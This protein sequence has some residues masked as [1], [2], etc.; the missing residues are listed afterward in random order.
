MENFTKFLGGK[1]SGALRLMLVVVGMVASFNLFSQTTYY[2]IGGATS[3]DLTVA[4]MW[5]LSL[6]G[7]SAGAITPSASNIF[8]VDGSDISSTTGTQTGAITFNPTANIAF[9]QFKLINNASLTLTTRTY[10]VGGT[11]SGDD[12]IV[13]SGSTLTLGT[14][15]DLT[16]ASSSP[17]STAD[18]SGSFTINASRTWTVT[19]SACSVKGGSII[20]TGLITG[21]STSTLIFEGASTYT[22]NQNGGTIPTADWNGA[23]G[24]GTSTCTVTGMTSTA[25]SGASQ[26]FYNL[27][28]NS[29][30]QSTTIA[31]TSMTISNNLTITATG[32]TASNYLHI[33][34]GN[35][36]T[37][38][39]NYSQ[40]GGIF[41]VRQTGANDATLSVSG[42]VSI[43]GG[44]FYGNASN[45]SGGSA[46][47]TC[48][49][50]FSFSAGTIDLNTQSS[51]T[52]VIDCKGDF[53]HT[54]GTIT[55]SGAGTGNIT[56]TKTSNTQTL[57]ST[58]Q[59]GDIN[60]TVSGSNA[61]C[62]VSS[63][64]TFVLGTTATFTVSNGTS[65]IDLKID[66]TFTFSGAAFTMN[67]TGSVS[68]TGTYTH[69][70][71]NWSST[72]A[73]PVFTWVSG[74]TCKVTGVTSSNTLNGINQTFSNF[75]WNC[76]TQSVDIDL[77]LAG[78]LTSF[79]C[80]DKFT[81]MSTGSGGNILKCGVQAS[82]TFTFN[83]GSMEIQGG[84][85]KLGDN[86]QLVDFN[87]TG[88][89]TMNG[90]TIYLNGYTST[91]TVDI[92]GNLD[93]NSGT[94]DI[95]SNTGTVTLTVTGNVS[96]DGG[97]YTMSSGS[98]NTTSS[99]SVDGNFTTSGSPTA[100]LGGSYAGHRITYNIKGDIDFATGGM[101][102]SNNAAST[103]AAIV[104]IN[105][106]GSGSKT[107]KLPTGL[108]N[109][110]GAYWKWIVDATRTVTLQSNVELGGSTANAC[111]FVNNG[112]LIM[113]T[114]I[115]TN[116]AS[117]ATPTFSNNASAT[118][119][120]AHAQGISTTASTG[121][122][123]V[124]GTKTFYSTASYEFN[125]NA[126]QVT[127]DFIVTTTPVTYTV[128]NLTLNNTAGVTLS[129]NITISNS[130]T[131][132]LTAGDHDL[133]TYTLTLGTTA[134]STLTY[135][136]G[137]LYS[138]SNAGYFKRYIPAG[139]VTS[140]SSNYYGLFPM[141]TSLFELNSTANTTVG[142]Y[143]TIQPFVNATP[144]TVDVNYSDGT[145]TIDYILN[146]NRIAL[147]TTSISGGT[148]TVKYSF[149]SFNSTGNA[150]DICLATY[151]ASTIGSQGTLVA[152][153][154][155]KANPVVARSSVSLANLAQTWVLGTYNNTNSPITS[156]CGTISGTRTVGTGGY[157][158]TLR[159]A[160]TDLNT[161]GIKGPTVFELL[162]TYTSTAE[163]LASS[164]LTITYGG[165]C[166]NSTNNVT[167]RPESA[168]NSVLS[169]SAANTSA[170][171]T[172]DGA[173]YIT[174]DGRPG[175]TGTNEYISITNTSIA[176]G[177]SAILFQN[178]ATNNNLQ[179]LNL[180]SSFPSATIGVVTFSGT[181]TT[182]GN[183]SNTIDNCIIDGNAGTNSSP[184]S[185]SSVARN[186][187][188]SGGNATYPNSTN[189]ISNS[190]FKNVFFTNST[191][192]SKM[193]A[194]D[195][196]NSSWTINGNSF[197]QTSPRQATVSALSSPAQYTS[198]YCI[199]ILG[200]DGYTISS[201]YIGGSS[202]N[203]S[204]TWTH[205]QGSDL[206]FY[207]I[208]FAATAGGQNSTIKSNT[209]SNFSAQIHSYK[210][211]WN[212]IVV[213]SGNVTLGGNTSADGNTI[214][215]SSGTGAIELYKPNGADG[216]TFTGIDITSI[217]TVTIKNNIIG[218]IKITGSS[219]Y[220]DLRGITTK[221][222][223]TYTISNNTIGTSTPNSIST[224]SASSS[225]TMYGIYNTGTGF[226]T[227]S[228]N[229]IG[230]FYQV[231]GSFIG[232][233]DYANA[234]SQHTISSNTI[235][236]TSTSSPV[237]VAASADCYG[238]NVDG[239]GTYTV[240]SNTIQNLYHTASATINLIGI[241]L[242]STGTFTVSNNTIDKLYNNTVGNY[243][244]YVTGISITA[245]I[246]ITSVIEKNSL[247]NFK[248]LNTNAPLISGISAFNT[249]LTL[250]AYNNFFECDNEGILN[251]NLLKI[252]GIWHQHS[253]SA[254][255]LNAYHNTIKISGKTS[256]NSTGSS[257]YGINHSGATGSTYNVQNNLIINTRIDGGSTSVQHVL[258]NLNNTTQN[259]N[260][261]FNKDQTFSSGSGANSIYNQNGSNSEPSINSDGSL[262][263][264]SSAIVLTGTN[265]TATVAT[266]K[267]GTARPTSPTLPTKGCYESG[268]STVYYTNN[269]TG[270][271][272]DAN[273][274][275]NWNDARA[276]S[277]SSPSNFSTAGALY[278]IQSGA[279]YK[280]TS[281]TFPAS[282]TANIVVE[283]G[284]ALDLNAQSFN[285]APAK[286]KLN[287][288]G[289]TAT[290]G[291]LRNSSASVTCSVPIELESAAT[292]TSSGSGGLTLSGTITNGGYTLTV[293]GAN[294]TTLS[295]FISGSGGLTKN[296][297]G[298][299]TVSGNNTFTGGVT[300]SVGTL[301]VNHDIALGTGTLSIAA[302]TILDALTSARSISNAMT[303][304][305]SFTF[306]GT[307][308]LTVSGN[309]SLA[310]SP[311]ITVTNSSANL[312]LSGV[313]TNGG[314]PTVVSNT[315][316]G[317]STWTCP[318]GVS[319]A[320]VYC[321]GGG[322]GSNYTRYRQGGAGGSSAY[323]NIT[324]TPNT[325]Y[326][327]TVGAGG[328]V[329][330]SG[331]TSG[332][333]G[334]STYFGNSTA[335]SSSGAMVLAVGGNGST[336]TGVN[337]GTITSNIGTSFSGGAGGAANGSNGPG[338]G[339][340]GAG[341]GS[342]GGNGADA[343]SSGAGAGGTGG[344]G[345]YA[346][347]AGGGAS[348]AG[349]VPGGG[350][351]GSSS[352]GAGGAGGVGKLVIEYYAT[353]RS[354]TKDGAGTLTLGG[355][356]TFS[357]GFTLSAGTVNIN[358]A[359]ALGL[360]NGTFTINGG[361]LNNTSGSSVTMIN[362]PMSWAGDFTF[363]GSNALNMGTGAV[364]IS[365]SRQVSTSA[366]TLTVGGIIS[367]AT[368]G[369]TKLGA[370]TMTLSGVN[371]YT[372]AT[373][374]TSGSLTM[375]VN[376]AIPVGGSGV[377]LNGGTLNTGN[378]TAGST[379][380]NIGTLTL[381]DNSTLAL[382][383]GTLYF[384]SSTAATWTAAKTL[385]VTGFVSSATSTAGTA[386]R[387]FVSYSSGNT[388]SNCG[389]TGSSGTNQLGLISFNTATING[390]A[391]V[392]G[393]T[394]L[395]SGE[396][397]P[398][399]CTNPLITAQPSTSTQNIC[400]GGS[401]TALSISATG[402]SVTYQWYSN[403]TASNSS[404]G[405]SI[406]GATSASYTPSAASTGTLYYYCIATAC[407][408]PVS[409]DVSA[410]MVVNTDPIW[411]TNTVT[412]A[413]ICAGGQVTF[414]ATVSGGL[415]N[416]ITWTRATSSG[417]A[418]STVTSPNTESS[419][420]TAYYRPV[421]TSSVS[422]C[423]LADGT[424]TSI[425]INARPSTAILA[426]S[427]TICNGSNANLTVTVTG[428]VTPYSVVYS[429]GTV[430]S[431]T[432]ASNIS[433]SPTTNTTYTL[434]SVTDA[435]GCTATTPSGSATVSVDAASV[436]GTAGSSQSITSGNSAALSLSGNTG[437]IQWQESADGAT[438]WTNVS[439]GSG[440]T[441]SAYTTATLTSTNY[442]R[443]VVTNGVCPSATSSAFTITVTSANA[444]ITLAANTIS[445]ASPC[446]STT[447]V[448]IQSFSLAITNGT[449]NLTNVGFTTTGSYVQA[450]IS[451]YQLYYGT[452]NS[453]GSA[454][455]LGSDV[456]S[457]GGTG[458]RTFSAFTSPALNSGS[459]YYFWITADVAAGATNDHTIAVNAIT[460]SDLTT[461]S[462]TAGTTSAGGTQTL[463]AAPTT[464]NAGSNQTSTA[465]C[466]ITQA[467]LGA[468]NPS[469][470]AGTWSIQ[471]GS[472]GSITSTS[473]YNTTFTGTLGNSY[474]LRWTISNG[475]CATSTS[476]VV[477][478]FNTPMTSPPANGDFVWRGTDN[479]W[480][481]AS[482]WLSHNG[483]SYSVAGSAP[484]SSNRV[485]ISA[486]NSCATVHP[487]LTA[488]ISVGS[489]IIEA[490]AELNQS[491]FNSTINGDFT[492]E[493]T[494][495]AGTG[496]TIFTNSA[497]ISGA[498]TFHNLV[499]NGV[500]TFASSHV[501]NNVLTL[502]NKINLG[503]NN[504][505]IGSSGV[506][507]GFGASHYMNTEDGGK[508]IQNGLGVGAA[509]GKKIFPV[510]T[511]SA[512]NPL[513][514]ENAG[515]SDNFS[516]AV[517]QGRL[518][519]GTSGSAAK[520]HA[521]DRTW[522]VEEAVGGGSQVTLT[523][524]WNAGDELEDL[525]KPGSA[526]NR[527]NC[528]ISH[529]DAISGWDSGSQTGAT[530]SGSG[531]YTISRDSITSFSPFGV[532]DPSALPITLIDFT[533]KAEGK[534]VRL[535]WETG[536]EEN[537]DFFTVERSLDGKK[538]EKVFTKKGAGNSKVNQF[539]FGYDANPYTGVSYYRLKQTDFDGKF[540]YSDIV[541][542]KVAG[543]QVTSEI[544]VNVYPNPV[545]SQLIHVDLKAQNNATYTMRIINEIGQQIFTD[546]Y[547]AFVGN[548]SYEIHLPNAVTGLYIVEISN[549]NKLVVDRVKVT[550]TNN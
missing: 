460:T 328:A 198:F 79:S 387:L 348:A 129:G 263:L 291:A 498:T 82:G 29:A 477:I 298:A 53:T 344:T 365:A 144:S 404:G 388:C 408:T 199:Q 54:G 130:G 529:Y 289:L 145:G 80:N 62:V 520:Q 107:L 172:L 448:P 339:G 310:S 270:T 87:C 547:D 18:I 250:K 5:S 470:G 504:L 305:G 543:E 26:P 410:A 398:I 400:S 225:G 135:T 500:I 164:S 72:K 337:I 77:G 92:G 63:S 322:G 497:I 184:S 244:S 201:N 280:L 351:G 213:T 132:A 510:G 121:C 394:Q 25:P 27:T 427:T 526:F 312:T 21:G 156:L 259:Y 119:K 207:G 524:Q 190:E 449:G 495:N 445:S 334:G 57:E 466:G 419:A 509:A 475:A 485:I 517:K 12:F 2:Y 479:T 158:A 170:I 68:S 491:S 492:N 15:A 173:D 422:G 49:G 450:D 516:V 359:S 301:N 110:G 99:V 292:I 525:A 332:G 521:V 265:L 35:T 124:T 167:I 148:F 269:Q 271:I 251:D 455:L 95:A 418:G 431:Y 316:A 391:A 278:I 382:G 102:T 275:S 490:G 538:F 467:T 70:V 279:N 540:A 435:N 131:L 254:I 350:G 390:V 393:A 336:S 300:L 356:N 354:L 227:I 330:T 345:T 117:A 140:N 506:I 478:T 550:I 376:N 64:K 17:S 139:A 11:I 204:G 536:S 493:G 375:G 179:Y 136:A 3:N 51:N 194:L 221:S 66:G 402:T 331:S 380:T 429:G 143:I 437:S 530:A 261:Y 481:T 488:D 285:T 238:I 224:A 159:A 23:T 465:T 223:A 75:I 96:V 514:I 231:N 426:G 321:I 152:N 303:V 438:G 412:P 532:E 304:N 335:G 309:V 16:M 302:S 118:L 277:G 189:T 6:G 325:T 228:N 515:T 47:L 181:N 178:G 507:S 138:S 320:T 317:N 472:G 377:V 183:N 432:S 43:S 340:G 180:T 83:V 39:G 8:I 89:F 38:Q 324:I 56:L 338:A 141:K 441:S 171:I 311:T 327:Y 126:A 157:Y 511:S 113:G 471:S 256:D 484:T 4:G 384:S 177:G 366:S 229:S 459:T 501:V 454:T 288:T 499:V 248:N 363:T 401:F 61:Q 202:A 169:L 264:A 112:T 205:T 101:K 436:L 505:T 10:T 103:G 161:N 114:Y 182:I 98:A 237:T 255:T 253:S 405:L 93:I 242:A 246:N 423:N 452:T 343:T 358:N 273:S 457:S 243:S 519:Y 287:G 239:T 281:N 128:A 122:I 65:T 522:Y 446:A 374:V 379:S 512:Y 69:N 245:A 333:N 123:Q 434:T 191:T 262:P 32:T 115:I 36:I 469:V 462:N 28:W 9:G 474:T 496:T 381:S 241:R 293:D 323:K 397:V 369:L 486:A 30:T 372:G 249:A 230:S 142:G 109:V 154:G 282:T 367:G 218:S 307:Q 175:G 453:L 60:W 176:T 315:T 41:Y 420:T 416:T 542:V 442:Y 272:I 407:S 283:S 341:S 406:L 203:C 94:F 210:S 120:T 48:N 290:S 362:Y 386:G 447:K 528:F 252:Y 349:S 73:L 19:G 14:N 430:N 133:A 260:Y 91:N 326:N 353:L 20:N 233:Y 37:V 226:V 58:G 414:S 86:S 45:S 346:G 155:T 222:T 295:G 347:G 463:K 361:T 342:N 88:D 461:T 439:G 527:L 258:N 314:T 67:G 187:V 483:S 192:D 533:A 476:D 409:S 209:I 464:A 134:A 116:S 443:V 137:R 534:K 451:K 127:G 413:S 235:G 421:Y 546:T 415:G 294:S 217:N 549:Q 55:K 399:S 24:T 306:T 160:I 389:L 186:G 200:G 13:A 59:T 208:S 188:Y 378:Y 276:G 71:N 468:N 257:S 125:G 371:T 1:R 90:G 487:T 111:S 162:S 236:A 52:G 403:T 234:L 494:F 105:L 22:H 489:L 319:S 480:S 40:S 424:E 308:D 508:V 220:Y 146:A 214:G 360:S 31:L 458:A 240:S 85:L 215:A 212:G 373:T 545:T 42:N 168:T 33:T 44:T 364:T 473:T 193:I 392:Y 151:T 548:N 531:P 195:V 153:S 196:N 150:S 357:G 352:D 268:I 266:D 108:T 518:L 329:G 411:A 274:T 544:D 247:T 163:N 444:T 539:Y 541:S 433:V 100:Y 297:S 313:I 296:G 166:L 318:A 417:G 456:S 197:Y 535:D 395:S 219:N 149:D 396:I 211:D 286:I 97:T 299:L 425:I 385:T 267:F 147:T 232:I 46:T 537:N 482:N 104:T 106:K 503:T 355:T 440:A 428:G 76:T 370:G 74:S 50:N 185:L 84:V 513:I 165:A 383:T 7:S 523:A 216:G 174:I 284:G 81:L 34:N 502:G 206:M 78:N 368:F